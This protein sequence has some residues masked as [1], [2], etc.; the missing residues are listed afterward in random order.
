MRRQ[1]WRALDVLVG[2]G[3]VE[4]VLRERA[5]AVPCFRVEAAGRVGE[6]E[7]RDGGR[8]FLR[9]GG[10]WL[11][12]AG[13]A[14]IHFMEGQNPGGDQPLD[15]RQRLLGAGLRRRDL[16]AARGDD[17]QPPG[18]GLGRAKQAQ[19]HPPDPARHFIGA[20]LVEPG[21]GEQ[22]R[23]DAQ[24]CR[25][26]AG[27]RCGPVECLSL[28]GGHPAR[29]G[30]G[31]GAVD[32]FCLR[33]GL[34]GFLFLVGLLSPPAVDPRKRR[35]RCACLGSSPR[36]TEE[37]IAER[38]R[39]IRHRLDHLDHQLVPLSA[40]PHLLPT[41]APIR[42]LSLFR[43]GERDVAFED[44]GRQGFHANLDSRI[45]QESRWLRGL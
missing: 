43:S 31:S 34:D 36:M 29:V 3:K 12:R 39:N 26:V 13:E 30:A 19:D 42:P 10:L 28:R 44:I 38:R 37:F 8:G 5:Q 20:A 6:W 32:K 11:W 41:I 33:T 35:R 7:R 9:L 15:P 4:T 21:I 24:E 1:R 27:N 16:D 2:V 17:D 14:E 23:D 45:A 22:H 18:G 25:A 40:S